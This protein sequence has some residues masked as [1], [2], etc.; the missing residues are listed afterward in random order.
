MTAE[1][2]PRDPLAETLAAW[3]S[4]RS[5]RTRQEYGKDLRRYADWRGAASVRDAVG[6]LLGGGAG[7]ANLLV[8]AYKGSMMD[9]GAASATVNRRL[10]VVRSVVSIAQQSG[11][12]DWALAVPGV[13][14]R[15]VLDVRGPS[16]AKFGELLAAEPSTRNRAI[17]GLL[18]Q[19]GLRCAEVLGVRLE[20]VGADGALT[21]MGKGR[22]E[23]EVVTLAPETST[24]LGAWIVERGRALGPLFD[25]DASTVRRIVETAGR[26]VGLDVNP[27]S[28]RHCAITRALTVTGGDVRAVRL[29]SRHADIRTVAAYDDARQD[30]AGAVARKVV[31]A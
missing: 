20:D 5:D 11:L 9:A 12:V 18:G 2:A 4:G 8:R 6:E 10:A 19:R 22:R 27:H 31:D 25:L 13:P 30:M 16:W 15:A 21:I 23:P 7:A 1:L 29:F 26:R 3:L 24:L 28:L 14:K 17:L